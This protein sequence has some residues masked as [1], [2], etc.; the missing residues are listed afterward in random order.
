MQWINRSRVAAL[1]VGSSSVGVAVSDDYQQA[2]IPLYSLHRVHPNGPLSE[3][4]RQRL[5][6]SILQH[7]ISGFVVGIPTASREFSMQEDFL[8]ILA[9]YHKLPIDLVL[10][11][12]ESYSSEIAAHLFNPASW[13]KKE[14]LFG[15]VDRKKIGKVE[16]RDEEAASVILSEYLGTINRKFYCNSG[17]EI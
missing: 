6:H 5:A 7:E 15:R 13:Q 10:W 16:K 2:A 12:D 3:E 11:W 14:R 17:G 9:A 1:D 4:S 8:Y